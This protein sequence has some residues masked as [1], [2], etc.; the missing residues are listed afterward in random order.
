M[1]A[2]FGVWRERWMEGYLVRIEV[3]ARIMGRI[4]WSYFVFC[5][6]F[7]RTFLGFR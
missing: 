6:Y 3:F 5:L 2:I 7:V 1:G 4:F